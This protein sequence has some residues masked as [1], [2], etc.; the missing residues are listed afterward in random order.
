MKQTVE[1]IEK[2]AYFKAVKDNES[3]QLLSKRPSAEQIQQFF[4]APLS[5]GR[6]FREMKTIS[7]LQKEQELVDLVHYVKSYLQE[8][9]SNRVLLLESEEN[10]N[11]TFE[12]LEDYEIVDKAEVYE[13]AKEE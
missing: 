3:M 12:G 13:K 1:I 5:L 9:E 6:Q 10:S 8:I 2:D 4:Y 11:E 7:K